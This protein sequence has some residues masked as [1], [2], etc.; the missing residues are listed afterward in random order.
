VKYSQ[1]GTWAKLST[2]TARHI[3]TGLMRG[4]AG[5]SP[6]LLL[7]PFGGVAT[8]PGNFGSQDLSAAG[9]GEW[10]F[11]CQEEKNLSPQQNVKAELQKVPGP[12]EY[13]FQCL[14]Q[15]NLVPGSGNKKE[16]KGKDQHQQQ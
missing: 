11:Q 15:D 4:G 13:G 7:E 16:I 9:P 10:Q 5:S 2:T 14:E 12:G 1:S 6:T 3:A 8:G